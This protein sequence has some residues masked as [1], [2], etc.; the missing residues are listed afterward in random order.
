MMATS[1]Q[2]TVTTIA[3]AYSQ[4]WLTGG[5]IRPGDEISPYEGSWALTD[6]VVLHEALRVEARQFREQITAFINRL[7]NVEDRQK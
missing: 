5:R 6:A 4:C 1:Y 3:N 7:P 2:P